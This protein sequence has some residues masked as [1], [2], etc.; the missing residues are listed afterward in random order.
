MNVRK[1]SPAA[2]ELADTYF[3]ETLVRIHREGEGAPYT[4][5]K[6]A[7]AVDP[8]VAG[9]DTALE[10]GKVDELV[11]AVTDKVA[12]GVRQRFTE[13][14]EKRPHKEHNQ[15]AGRDYV[16]AYVEFIHYVE[17]LNQDA[18][19]P[20]HDHGESA[21]ASTPQQHNHDEK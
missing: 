13:A 2:K 10:T 19:G 17:K 3:F 12:A 9:A 18:S 16:R 6:P 21:E 15:A 11:K 5:L 20:A 1:Q 7:G 8:A 4:G 14:N